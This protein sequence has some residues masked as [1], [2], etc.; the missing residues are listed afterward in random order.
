[1]PIKI[2]PSILASDFLSLKDQ[3]PLVQ[4]GGADWLHL[5]IMDGRFV[6]NI[7]IGPPI[8]A[9]IR[10]HT[11]LPLDVHLM[12]DDPDK[13]LDVFREAGADHITVH[14]E[15][16]VHLHRTIA[17]IKELGALAGVALNPATPTSMLADIIADVDLVLVMSVNPGFGGQKF[18]PG[19]LQRISEIRSMA[20][21]AKK[22]LFIEVDGGIDTITARSV[23][24]AGANVLV[25]GT[26]IFHQ[27]NI[28]QAV[29]KLRKSCS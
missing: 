11:M 8:I 27:D 26:A 17:R 28:E 23:V 13:Y 7:T 24:R 6:P 10:K 15:A 19:C 5:D 18:I 2:A 25:A 16:C 20:K 1:M 4:K 21:S 14:Q 3:L 22:R 29:V 9:S 12:I